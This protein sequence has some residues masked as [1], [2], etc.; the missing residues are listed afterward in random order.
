MEV[1]RY[2]MASI[3]LGAS[4]LFCLVICWVAASENYRDGRER[5]ERELKRKKE[6]ELSIP[7][8][9]IG[10]HCDNFQLWVSD[11]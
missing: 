11:Y 10:A 5:K 2:I 7:S 8:E 9:R 1:I 4:M 3:A 6:L